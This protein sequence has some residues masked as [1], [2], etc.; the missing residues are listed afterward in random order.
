MNF[1]EKQKKPILALAP[2]AGVTDAA[3]RIVCREFGADVLYSEMASVTALFYAPEKTL[4]LLSFG[5]LETPYVAQ[6]F[7]SD[8][9][10][11]AHAAQMVTEK[12]KPQGIDINF[13][14]P[15][16]K[17]QKQGAGAVLMK[18][19]ARARDCIK[20][21]LDNTDLSV[22]IKTRTQVDDKNV[23][24]FLDFISDLDIK[25]LMI[26][27]RTLAQGFA[28]PIDTEIITK[29]RGYFGGIILANGGIKDALEAKR[30]LDETGAD[31]LG[32]ARGA[33]GNPW[34]FSDIKK[35]LFDE[36]TPEKHDVSEIYKTALKQAELSNEI[37]GRPG[38]IEMR[39]HLCWYL[40]GTPSAAELRSKAVAVESLED[41]RR[42]LTIN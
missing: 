12:I 38:I 8:P 32:I 3:F 27:G 10:H 7:G 42:V 28:G 20:A 18:D 2:M 9:A 34:L 5:E 41:V 1:W 30:I 13:G 39:K 25:A 22:S 11:F 15:V 17:V 35:F 36:V 23:L 14:C 4:K 26:H 16:K 21:V 40:H 19:F 33:M 6:L 37:L 24:Q 31:G 29:A